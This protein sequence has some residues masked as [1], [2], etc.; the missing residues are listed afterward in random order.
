METP[1]SKLRQRREEIV[2]RHVEADNGHDVAA[3]HDLPARSGMIELIDKGSCSDAHP[4][5]LLF[6]HG[7]WHAAWCWDDHFL[8]FFAD[9]GF[10]AVALSLRGHGGSSTAKPLNSCS[11]ADYVQDVRSVAGGL[12]TAPVLIG[13]SMGGFVVQKYLEKHRAPAAVLMASMPS[14]VMRRAA[15]AFRVLR[16]HPWV[17]VRANTVGNSGDLVNTPAL[18]REH[19]FCASTPEPTVESCAARLQPESWRGLG[20][21]VLSK[22][23]RVTTPL[24][25]L[26]GENDSTLT[27]DG[28]RA[29]ARAFGTQAELL[30]GLGHNM[31]LETGWPNVAERIDSWLT[32]QGI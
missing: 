9:A 5:P 26:G 32:S 22:P 6:I 7:G 30:P 3:T 2:N 29:T 25:V 11:I 24:L 13:H 15:V 20:L 28:V 31:M 27:N 18:A 17:T 10:R 14:Q 12:P 4:T 1:S 8:D 19:L 16:S 21:F 23:A